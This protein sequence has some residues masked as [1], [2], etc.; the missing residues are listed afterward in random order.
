MR[1]RALWA[2]LW[3]ATLG[4]AQDM[5]IGVPQILSDGAGYTWDIQQGGGVSEGS[6]DAYDGAMSLTI[7]GMTPPFSPS[8]TSYLEGRGIRFM[9][10]GPAAGLPD[11]VMI[12]RWVYVPSELGCAM[13]IDVIENTTGGEVEVNYGIRSDFGSDGGTEI[14]STSS[15]DTMVDDED[16]AAISDDGF[17]SSDPAIVH[18]W[19]SEDGDLR[20]SVSLSTGTDVMIYSFPALR[21]GPGDRIGVAYVE[22]QRT[23]REDAQAFLDSFDPGETIL[24]LAELADVSL[25]NFA[26][27]RQGFKQ[28]RG[29]DADIL[30]LRGG[31][32]LAGEILVERYVLQ[33]SH[34]PLEVAPER[35]A[36]VI[37]GDLAADRLFLI[38]G[39]IIA[40]SLQLETVRFRM[41]SGRELQASRSMLSRLGYRKRADE[42]EDAL[43]VTL[44]VHTRDGAVYACSPKDERVALQTVF[45]KIELPW[46][47]VVE[48]DLSG[49][50][51]RLR[52][53]SGSSLHG[54]LL[55][56]SLAFE[57]SLDYAFPTRT[58]VRIMGQ[59][60]ERAGAPQVIVGLR[61]GDAVLGRPQ[62]E[63]ISV[64]CALGDLTL[65]LA[66][67]EQIERDKRQPDLVT[68]V[69]RRSGTLR[70]SWL[71]GTFGF[72]L[73]DGASLQLYPSDCLWIEF[74]APQAD[75]AL[76]AEIEE[77]I[78]Q[79][80]SDDYAVR[81]AAR[82]R[83][84][85]IGEAAL[86]ALY[87]AADTSEDLE[88]Q[89]TARELIEAIED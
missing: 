13:W 56:E 33:T 39:E 87:Q 77:A 69:L 46:Q 25:L 16:W 88:V 48:V 24:E 85:E 35:V 58:L 84:L 45:G 4:W 9:L 47:Q 67:I 81:E 21:V 52:L 76:Q 64:R 74:P 71:G 14:V 61:N 53:K 19:G 31:D 2:V 78:A 80:Y 72:E 82:A 27:G 42:P 62:L 41:A 10:E 1:R 34:G 38:N 51:H 43:S 75:P 5:T 54:L 28:L 68:I 83:L 49:E 66:E 6:S 20:P 17:G 86:P 23:S 79:L 3:A 55:A 11:G 60:K 7:N 70:G 89:L 36:S 37:F 50:L 40:G 57:G 63:E 73:A 29:E 26:G 30:E 59:E 44:G 22:A 15:G 8:G 65:Q 18:I 12:E 32:F